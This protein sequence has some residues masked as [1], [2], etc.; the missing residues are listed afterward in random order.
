MCVS[1]YNSPLLYTV[2]YDLIKTHVR[3]H[4]HSHME[5]PEHE[6]LFMPRRK[7]PSDRID[8][9]CP[10]PS[11]AECHEKKRRVE[12]QL[13][14]YTQTVFMMDTEQDRDRERRL[15]VAQTHLKRVHTHFTT[16]PRH[17]FVGNVVAV[18]QLAAYLYLDSMTIT[19]CC[20]YW[21]GEY[22]NK[23]VARHLLFNDIVEG[24]LSH[25]PALEISS[26]FGLKY[27]QDTQT[28]HCKKLR[29]MGSPLHQIPDVHF[30]LRLDIQQ[31][32]QQQQQPLIYHPNHALLKGL[33]YVTYPLNQCFMAVYAP[34]SQAELAL[35]TFMYNTVLEEFFEPS[36][37]IIALYHFAL[38]Q[39]EQRIIKRL[40]EGQTVSR[41]LVRYTQLE[42]TQWM[43]ARVKLMC[44]PLRQF[45]E[46]VT[47][48]VS[49]CGAGDDSY[50]HFP[51]LAACIDRHDSARLVKL[52]RL[53][54]DLV[55]LVNVLE[56]NILNFTE[57]QRQL[58]DLYVA[59]SDYCASEMA[60]RMQSV[61]ER[62]HEVDVS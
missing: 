48:I 19:Q 34:G 50:E 45:I 56:E 46:Q 30:D 18:G 2:G 40:F 13:P 43:V 6:Q 5:T 15:R 21:L 14:V 24:I 23:K 3:A 59:K 53:Y 42:V 54:C 57:L 44:L 47:P 41:A 28:T 49:E 32:Q 16:L 17:I 1:L 58:H 22:N 51:A 62:L 39:R 38:E 7:R 12:E 10:S 8:E 55:M 27:T 20:F 36:F 60:V 29:F 37:V 4:T 26:Q 52:R 33:A 11:L 35:G 61:L 25:L 31:Q 9:L